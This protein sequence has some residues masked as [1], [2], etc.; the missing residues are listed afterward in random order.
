TTPGATAAYLTAAI[1]AHIRTQGY[2]LLDHPPADEE[3]AAHDKIA[4]VI[5]GEGS[6]A[7]LTGA[8]AEVGSWVQSVLEKTFAAASEPSQLVKIRM[9]G[10]TVPTDKLVGTLSRPF[11]MVPLVNADNNQHTHNEN[12]RVGHYLNGVGVFAGLLQTP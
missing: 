12:L 11:V 4:S 9:M 7:A 3:R 6:D 10:G 5:V 1:Q 8:D 2:Y